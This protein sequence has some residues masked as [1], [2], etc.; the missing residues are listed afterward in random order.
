MAIKADRECHSRCHLWGHFYRNQPF[1]VWCV[2]RSTG[3]ILGAGNGLWVLRRTRLPNFSRILHAPCRKALKALQYVITLAD[4]AARR[5]VGSVILAFEDST[6]YSAV[7]A[8]PSETS[9]AKDLE[10]VWVGWRRARRF[11]GTR[12]V[13]LWERSVGEDTEPVGEGE[14]A[15]LGSC[16]PDGLLFGWGAVLDDAGFCHDAIRL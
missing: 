12:G 9:G 1:I 16:L 14:A 6:A 11:W 8:N 5:R 10:R 13:V 4:E 15:L 7:L 3:L 2:V